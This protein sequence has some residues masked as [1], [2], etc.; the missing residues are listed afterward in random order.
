V[1][2]EIAKENILPPFPYRLFWAKGYNFQRDQSAE[3]TPVPALFLHWLFTTVLII[4]A[5]VGIRSSENAGRDAYFFVVSVYAYVLDVVIFAW[6]AL[7][8]LYL[9]IS[10]GSLWYS[11]SPANHWVSIIAAFIFLSS[12]TFPLICMWIPDPAKKTLAQSN[13]IAWYTSQTVGIAV[14]VFA[15]L[16][17]LVFRYI[18]PRVGSHRGRELYSKRT[19]V[20]RKEAVPGEDHYYLIRTFEIVETYWAKSDCA[21]VVDELRSRETGIRTET[22]IPDPR[23]A[24][25]EVA[26]QRY[27]GTL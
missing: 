27:L 19:P 21:D 10:P 13:R 11:I 26:S 25:R 20:F 4:A 24:E 18:V 15:I 1:K 22:S 7:G 9:R 14:F 2:Q 16:Y 5:L 6:I 3:L 12:T 8:V 23:L 17:W